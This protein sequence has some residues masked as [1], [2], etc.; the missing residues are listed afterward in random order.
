M[1]AQASKREALFITLA[2]WLALLLTTATTTTK[3]HAAKAGNVYNREPQFSFFQQMGL[4]GSR[5][6]DYAQ[7]IDIP[8]F[9]MLRRLL[10]AYQDFGAPIQPAWIERATR[11]LLAQ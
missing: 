10:A 6:I 8:R 5:D 4:S 3:T 1:Y 9:I 11:P 2:G 7:F